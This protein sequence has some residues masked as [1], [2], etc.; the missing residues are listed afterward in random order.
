MLT[1]IRR[2][3]EDRHKW[4]KYVHGGANPRIEDGQRTEQNIRRLYGTT[5]S[6]YG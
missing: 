1:A 4:G 6:Q 3:T 5:V 2:Y